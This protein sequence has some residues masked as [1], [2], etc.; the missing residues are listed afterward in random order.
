[1]TT[2]TTR[3]SAATPRR[4][5]R[6]DPHRALPD[7][8]AVQRLQPQHRQLPHRPWPDRLRQTRA[9]RLHHLRAHAGRRKVRTRLRPSDSATPHRSHHLRGPQRRTRLQGRATTRG[10]GRTPVRVHATT[11]G[12][13]EP[14]VARCRLEA[15]SSGVRGYRPRT[16]RLIC[17]GIR[18]T[19]R[20]SCH[21][22]RQCATVDT[23]RECPDRAPAGLAPARFSAAARVTG[24]PPAP[25]PPRAIGSPG[26]WDADFLARSQ[27]P[28]V[29]RSWQTSAMNR[30]THGRR[31][32]QS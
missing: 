21:P 4:D 13:D 1:M 8:R 32:P 12:R 25:P 7:R 11:S 24:R 27:H 6:H 30:S 31:R 17:S 19:T 18:A 20:H 10:T 22:A 23:S 9:R 5:Q 2:D 26:V 15:I 16:N 29:R 14:G 3:P 28:A